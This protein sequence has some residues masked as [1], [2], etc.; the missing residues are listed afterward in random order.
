MRVQN[1]IG[2][3]VDISDCLFIDDETNRALS[4]SVIQPG[5]V[6]ISIAGTIGRVSIVP[7]GSKPMNCNQ[8][9]GIVR[10]TNAIDRKY[11]AMWLGTNDAMAQIDTSKVTATISNLSLGQIKELAV[12]LPPIATQQ[13]IARV[14]EQADQLRK[15]AQ[16]MENELNHLA[17]SLF[18]EMFG[19]PVTNPKRWPTQLLPELLLFQEGPGVR[20][21]QFR[22]SGIKLLNVRNI[23]NGKLDLSNTETHLDSEEVKTRYSHFLVNEGDLV[24]ASSGATWGKTAWVRQEHLPLCMNT[25]TIRFRPHDQSQLSNL[26]MWGFL[27]ST[28]FTRQIER[29]ITGSAQPNF[30]PA[31]LKQVK[32]LLPSIELQ[33]RFQSAMERVMEM[34]AMALNEYAAKSELFESLMQRAFNGELTERKAA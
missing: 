6:L 33:M 26:Y 19:D 20:N 28:A 32:M 30:G 21:W 17:Q 15:Q 24:M 11:L 12:P 34:S 16:Q 23:V 13:H 31:H 8:A 4:R 10:P 14:L 1:L 7:D 27:N 25:S 2:G 9:V 3:S 18:L 5:D 22:N 29:L